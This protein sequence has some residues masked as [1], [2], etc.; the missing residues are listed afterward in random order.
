[1]F[2]S[3]A[4]NYHCLVSKRKTMHWIGNCKDATRNKAE[5]K[6]Q[7]ILPIK[8]FSPKPTTKQLL[9]TKHH[10]LYEA[11]LSLCRYEKKNPQVRN[12]ET[13]NPTGYIPGRC[14]LKSWLEEIKEKSW[15]ILES[16]TKLQGTKEEQN[17][18][19]I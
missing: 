13:W 9:L 12:S 3:T 1:M 14:E 16:K 6:S 19:K 18:L 2:T 8:S 5:N 11:S 4:Y 7:N 17:W 10:D 15:I